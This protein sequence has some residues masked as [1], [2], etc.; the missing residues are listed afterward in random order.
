MAS[1]AFSCAVLNVSPQ[2]PDPAPAARDTVRIYAVGDMNLGRRIARARLERAD[3]LYPFRGLLDTLRGADV[4]FG[5]L[6]S[7]IAPDSQPVDTAGNR[8]TAP[9]LAAEALARAGFDI[10]SLA[11]NHAWDGYQ[12]GLRESM[13]RLSRAG[14]LFVGAGLGREMAEQPVIV[15]SRGW[16]IAFVGVTR[17][18]NPAPYEFYAHEGADWVAW[19]D[20]RWVYPALRRLKREGRADLVV[21][22]VHGGREYVDTPPS[23]HEEFLRGLVD[24]GA[25]VVLAHHPHVLQPVTWHHGKPIAQS[26]GNFVFYQGKPWTELSAVLRVTV[27][28]DGAITVSAIPVRADF[29]PRVVTGAAADS[30]RERL[31]VPLATDPPTTRK[32]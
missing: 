2:G 29:Q 15:R 26:L 30:V 11:N 31:H 13:H 7:P 20:P 18:W 1:L 28:P 23:Y 19:G 8:F 22:S 10:V 4:M 17:A 12:A 3:T 9:R 6:E 32:P 25:D 14:V 24:A 21:V 16:R 5:N 27:A